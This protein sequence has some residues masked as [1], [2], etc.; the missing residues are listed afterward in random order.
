MVG[1]SISHYHVLDEL[2]SGG[3]GVVFRAEDLQLGR[4]VAIKFLPEEVARDRVALERFQREART[5]SALNHPHICTVYELG[6]HEGHAF[7]A[8]ELLEGQTLRQRIA[9]KPLK[10]EEV[11][12]LGIQ[13]ADA[14]DAAHAKGIVHRDIKPANIFVTP[15]GQAKVLDFGLAKLVE[16]G[17]DASTVTRAGAVA[18]TPAYM[19]PE[20]A[21]GEE[22]DYRTDLFSFGAVLYEMTTGKL[23][24]PGAAGLPGELGRIIA[25]ALEQERELRY[26]TAAE[27]RAD[28]KR[29]ARAEPAP[30]RRWWLIPATAVMVIAVVA[31]GAYLVWRRGEE[32]SWKNA[33]FTR[34]THL[35]SEELYPSLA[36]DGKSFVFQSRAAG[37]WDIYLQRVGGK[38]PMNL[39][40][41]SPD[42]D[43]QPAFSPD[44]ERI[45]FRSERQGGGIFVMGATGESVKRLTDSG[46]N[47]AWSPDSKQIVYSSGWFWWAT[48]RTG[49]RYRL[50]VVDAGGASSSGAPSLVSEK[51]ADAMQ[52]NW[53][54]RGR[55][56]AFWGPH[57][58][59]HD[60]WTVAAGGGEPVRVTQE[61]AVDWN[62]VWSPDGRHLYFSSDRG[63]SMNL[64][65]V[66]IEED[67][68][69]V[70]GPAE[71]VTTPSAEAAH[72]SFARDGR[73]LIYVNR[74]KTGNISKIDFDPG[75]ETVVGG[76]APV[77][78]GSWLAGSPDVS[79]DGERLTF[80]T[81]SEPEDL[82]VIRTD[83]AGQSQ[84]T[85][86][87]YR[88]RRPQWSPDGKRIAFYS[89][90]GG[91]PSQIWTINPDG[92]GLRQLT[93]DPKGALFPVWSPDGLRLAY[94]VPDRST[95]FILDLGNPGEKGSVEALPPAPGRNPSFTAF[96]WSPDGRRLA[97]TPSSGGVSV[98]SFDSRR[99]E[100]FTDYG[101]FPSWLSDSRR[102]VFHT[103]ATTSKSA[104][105][106]LDTR[107]G[108]VS[109]ILSVTPNEIGSPAPSRDDRRIYFGL[110]STEADVW[111]MS[112][113]Y[114]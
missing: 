105:Y 61:P 49:S 17:P 101:F 81:S 114:P 100:H 19:S 86:D 87:D 73:R 107:T 52:P 97:G 12:E 111:M 83:G 82:H 65:R 27:L 4:H 23:P 3:M 102:L 68:G 62:P 59:N 56:I 6:E 77:T 42:D 28:L 71:P 112:L 67:S 98:Y 47:P 29:L 22:L 24:L 31:A 104:M 72:F 89:N 37:N 79:P 69:K 48:A 5:A 38:N 40:K 50:W 32:S 41:D 15:R 18:G 14:L 54:P 30:R 91:G 16:T 2:G 8:M 39:T 76:P 35:P 85:G 36:A 113:P 103:F 109:E 95:T 108:R 90:R 93:R 53:S 110:S 10:P 75:R 13:L 11:I 58:G 34:L 45:A 51:I 7:I 44:G 64:W 33:T 99:Y 94:T 96:S 20:Q 1:K 80:A 57:A 21:R 43:T 63:G 106:L 9:G 70:L 84:I 25:K 74:L 26:Q 78:K 92:S 88:D 60:V 55:R 46:Y 66:R